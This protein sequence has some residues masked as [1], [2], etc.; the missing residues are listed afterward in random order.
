MNEPDE[1][2][3]GISPLQYASQA[4]RF[5]R[6]THQIKKRPQPVNDL[7]T[8]KIERFAGFEQEN[9]RRLKSPAHNGAGHLLQQL[10]VLCGEWCVCLASS[11]RVRHRAPKTVPEQYT[12]HTPP[13]GKFVRDGQSRSLCNF[14]DTGTETLLSDIPRC[15]A[16]INNRM[17]TL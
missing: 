6:C 15:Y 14:V 11:K 12:R 4:F 7:A 10:K 3:Y 16:G 8:Q 17:P 9:R 2:G 13:Y 5:R 1:P